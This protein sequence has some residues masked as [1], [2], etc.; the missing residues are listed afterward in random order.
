MKCIFI[1]NQFEIHYRRHNTFRVNIKG[2]Y[3]YFQ[4]F[5][6]VTFSKREGKKFRKNQGKRESCDKFF[7]NN[8]ISI[9]IQDTAKNSSDFF[10]IIYT[11]IL[12]T[13]LFNLNNN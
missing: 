1:P 6:N 5:S 3:K 2:K 9:L 10:K 7:F 8:D 12:K 11:D 13:H 4:Q